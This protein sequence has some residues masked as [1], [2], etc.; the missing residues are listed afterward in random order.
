MRVYWHFGKFSLASVFRVHAVSS[1]SSGS[2][3]GNSSRSGLFPGGSVLSARARN[4]HTASA[5]NPQHHANR[6]LRNP[7]PTQIY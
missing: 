7:E 3:S 2:C 6:R 1:H 4:R 5:N